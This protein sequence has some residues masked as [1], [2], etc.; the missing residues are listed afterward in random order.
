MIDTEH[1]SI[2]VHSRDD[3][4]IRRNTNTVIVRLI[5]EDEV[6][7]LIKDLASN[8]ETGGPI[9]IVIESDK[10]FVKDMD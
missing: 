7:T 10:V 8:M 4:L 9:Y 2:V 5:G 6:F 1:G 3:F